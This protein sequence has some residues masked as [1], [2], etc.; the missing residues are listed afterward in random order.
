MSSDTVGAELRQTGRELTPITDPV[1]IDAESRHTSREPTPT[2]RPATIDAEPRVDQLVTHE[3]AHF[4]TIKEGLAY[5]LVPQGTPTSTDPKALKED[6]D[7]QSVFYNPIQQF[8]RDLSVLAIRAFGEDFVVAQKLKKEA[9][10]NKPAN[11]RKWDKKRQ[12]KKELKKV[13]KNIENE[14]IGPQS[15][16]KK[17]K[18][19]GNGEQAEVM[20]D[21]V[22]ERSE[23]DITAENTNVT[24]PQTQPNDAVPGLNGKTPP[25]KPDLRILD[26]LSA[27]GL[28]ALRY[29]QELP[30]AAAV[31]ANDMSQKATASI[32]LNVQHNK[33]ED[34]ITPNAGNAI[35]HMYSFVGTKGYDV[36]DLDPYGT[37]APFLDSALQALTNGGLLC[38]TCTD[39]GVF[40]STGYLEK[41][42]SQYGG[43]PIKGFHSHEGGLR[44]IIHAIATSAARYGMAIEPL[45]SLSIDY[46]ARVFVRVRRSPAEVKFLAGK[47]M[48]VYNCDAGCGAWQ[49]QFLARNIPREN[50]DGSLYY[51]HSFAQAPSASPFCE[52]CGT[53][54]HLSGPMY[55]GPLHNPAFIERILSYLTTIDK[56]IYATSARIEG[57]LQTAYEETLVEAPVISKR[58]KK[59]AE[60]AETTEN[61]TTNTDAPSP[62]IPQ[63]DPAQIDHH[64]FYFT[65]SNLSKVI[66]CQAPPDAAIRGALRKAGFRATRSHCKPGTIRTDAS[67][68]DLWHIMREWVRR[69]APVREGALSEGSAGWKIL[70]LGENEAEEEGDGEG[71]GEQEDVGKGKGGQNYKVVFDEQLGRDEGPKLMRYQINPRANWG[72]MNRAK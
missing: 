65:P 18:I 41:T 3:G 38:V 48:L 4:T 64:P 50:K 71:E 37:A 63:T 54:T 30:F 69:R 22:E 67:W 46:Y 6:A 43:L 20:D 70:R 29:A 10:K 23:G 27:T 53:K 59:P 14:E 34:R 32:A 36:I 21:T 56:E 42:Y 39:S 68:K 11:K 19:E 17:R 66:H 1:A 33:L 47:Q 72:P 58:K 49:T 62:S 52:H 44:L 7:K 12:K 24:Y 55:G 26:A 25:F 9:E 61:G 31:T 60:D 8:N 15:P 57:M 28:R 45:L 35:S 16:A 13:G 2:T 5:I 40:A 51:K